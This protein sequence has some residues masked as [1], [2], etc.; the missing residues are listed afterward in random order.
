MIIIPG[1]IIQYKDE[2]GVMT[3]LNVPVKDIPDGVRVHF[4]GTNWM[5]A[6][7]P[8][9]EDQIVASSVSLK[10]IVDE[11]KFLADSIKNPPKDP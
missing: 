7:D 5:I 2:N 4:D 11:Q 6:E 1:K 8:K 10:E 9:D 3:D